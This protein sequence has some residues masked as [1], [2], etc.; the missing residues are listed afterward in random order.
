MK[1]KAENLF[2]RVGER[3]AIEKPIAKGRVQMRASQAE[4]ADLARTENLFNEFGERPGNGKPIG[5]S[6]GGGLAFRRLLLG[7]SLVL[8]LKPLARAAA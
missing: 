8:I 1:S 4:D 2:N 6:R 3:S 5:G 7:I